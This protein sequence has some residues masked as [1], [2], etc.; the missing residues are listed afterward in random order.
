MIYDVKILSKDL[1]VKRIIP[2]KELS[3]TFWKRQGLILKKKRAKRSTTNTSEDNCIICDKLYI[4]VSTKQLSCS[5]RCALKRRQQLAR[6]LWVKNNPRSA[7]QR[8]CQICKKDFNPKFH[9]KTTCSPECHKKKQLL[10]K[11]ALKLRSR[12]KIKN[13]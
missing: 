4:K 12:K 11:E 9:K 6:E 1:T 7:L 8:I 5:P 10:L 13:K 2:A 3:I